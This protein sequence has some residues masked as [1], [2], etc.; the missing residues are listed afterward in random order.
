MRRSELALMLRY[1]TLCVVC[2]ET[3]LC[4][5]LVF[6]SSVSFAGVVETDWGS[7]RH[8]YEERVLPVPHEFCFTFVSAA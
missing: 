4:M 7:N 5:Y 3:Y 6:F 2:F 8:P 1:H